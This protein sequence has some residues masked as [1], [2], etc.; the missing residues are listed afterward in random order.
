MGRGVSWAL[1]VADAS[2]AAF[3]SFSDSSSELDIFGQIE[4]LTL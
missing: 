1:G 4:R 2:A 3:L